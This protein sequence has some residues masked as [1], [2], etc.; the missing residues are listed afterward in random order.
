VAG[1]R[2]ERGSTL[3]DRVLESF[4]R[5]STSTVSD[6]LERH[7]IND[8]CSDLSPFE[9]HARICG[10]AFTVSYVPCEAATRPALDYIDE[11]PAGAVVVIDVGGRMDCAVWGDL[12]SIT[13]VTRGFGGT[14]VDGVCRDTLQAIELGYPVFAR[15]VFSHAAKGRVQV[16]AINVPVSLGDV[17][18]RPNDI[19]VADRDGVVV[20]PSEIAEEV[21]AAAEEIVAS[22]A[23]IKQAIRDGMGFHAALRKFR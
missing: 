4:A 19:V 16:D 9:P 10:R 18:V 20:V 6:A 11:I 5:H 15:G 23:S 21:L 14:I 3:A 1:R 12:R 2:D 17:V 8:R 22:E 7:G 13:A